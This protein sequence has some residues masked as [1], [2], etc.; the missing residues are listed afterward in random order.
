MPLNHGHGVSR[1]WDDSWT[2]LKEMP[3]STYLVDTYAVYAAL[4]SAASTVF[5]SLLGALLPLAGDVRH[6][7]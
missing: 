3:A 4:V 2:D 5:P 1:C 7:S 6:L